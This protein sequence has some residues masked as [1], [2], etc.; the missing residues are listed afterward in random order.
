MQKL[1]VEEALSFCYN[2]R[3][4]QGEDPMVKCSVPPRGGKPSARF[5]QGG[6]GPGR[7]MIRRNG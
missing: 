3:R 1:S 2:G 4:L 6:V 7:N 5:G